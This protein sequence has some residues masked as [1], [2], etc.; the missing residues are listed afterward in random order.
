MV[1]QLLVPGV[2]LHD[3]DD[4][5][6]LRARL[7]WAGTVAIVGGGFI[8]LEVAA[9]ARAT[10]KP[11]TLV[12][13]QN[14]LMSRCVVRW[15]PEC[16]REVH[17]AEG[18]T[19]VLSSTALPQADLVVGGIGVLPNVELAQAAGL[20]VRK[21]I[22]VDAFLKTIDP[23]HLAIGDCAEAA[24]GMCLESVQNAADQGKSV[25]TQIVH[26]PSAYRAVPWFWTDQF[27]VKLQMAGISSVRH[28]A[29]LRGTTESRKFSVFYFDAAG[30]LTGGRFG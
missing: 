20:T 26:G 2:Y 23:E 18:V 28:K 3:R 24:N 17:T 29:V 13:A 1:R 21:G 22:V 7:E 6:E 5:V 9:A 11:V 8:G 19:V 14:R 30:R 25:A 12:E 15:F 4:G 27:D 10:G 16:F